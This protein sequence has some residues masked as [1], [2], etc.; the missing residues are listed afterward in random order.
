[1]QA[2]IPNFQL[3][4]G[5]YS[6]RFCV[7]IRIWATKYIRKKLGYGAGNDGTILRQHLLG[8]PV[9][10]FSCGNAEGAWLGGVLDHVLFHDPCWVHALWL[11][12]PQFIVGVKGK[13]ASLTNGSNSDTHPDGYCH[14]CVFQF[15]MNKAGLAPL[16][17]A[18]FG[19]P[20]LLWAPL[21]LT[22]TGNIVLT[23]MTSQAV[24]STEPLHCALL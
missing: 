16:W 9:P 12:I 8:P 14:F 5:Q 18:L 23:A 17:F 7:W 15:K 6:S 3:W 20:M 10:D 11:S 1:M 24:T 19:L 13:T 2:F 22:R 21:L 4:C